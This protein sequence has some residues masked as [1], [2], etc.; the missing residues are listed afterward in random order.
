LAGAG[1]KNKERKSGEDAP[2]REYDDPDALEAGSYCWVEVPKR[3][4]MFG[5]LDAWWMVDLHAESVPEQ[6]ATPLVRRCMRAY[7]WA[8][9]EARSVLR[10]YRQF[11]RV[12]KA[13]EDWKAE[14][15]SP[16]AAVDRMWH[17]HVL[18]SVNY[19][20]D[21]QLLCGRFLG[22]NPDGALDEEAKKMRLVATKEALLECYGEGGVD[23]SPT[24]PWKEVFLDEGSSPQPSE[25]TSSV[26]SGP[27]VA[28]VSD[29]GAP[30]GIQKTLM[31]VLKHPITAE[32]L[33]RVRPTTRMGIVDLAKRLGL[34]PWAIDGEVVNPHHT[35]K[36]LELEDGDQVDVLWDNVVVLVLQLSLLGASVS[37]L[38]AQ[39]T[40]QPARTSEMLLSLS[41]L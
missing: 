32:T 9:P 34:D 14:L 27:A 2:E 28:L 21:C 22:H 30:D 29:D 26:R 6:G 5:S 37:A 36:S 3:T 35:P 38:Q 31:L 17:Q 1:N 11:L 20:H 25:G 23:R 16:S 40:R 39:T 15:L 18:D 12:K 41:K 19:V 8:E 10:A 24:G 7:G 33:I 13:K 4:S